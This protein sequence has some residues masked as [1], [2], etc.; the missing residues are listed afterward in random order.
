[1]IVT[2]LPALLLVAASLVLGACASDDDKL[3]PSN[4]FRDEVP[5]RLQ[6]LQ[7][8]EV[9][10]LARRSLDAADYDGAIG[11]YRAILLRF[12]FSEYATQAQLELI[13]ANYKSYS[14][15]SALADAD[16]FLRE[17]PRHPQIEYVYYLRGLIHYSRANARGDLLPWSDSHTYDPTYARRAFDAFAQLIQRYPDSK[18]APDARQ[19]MILLRDRLTQ[20]DLEIVR[21][22]LKRKAYVGASRRAE[23]MLERYQGTS[24]IPETLTLL[25]TAYRKL[26]LTELADATAALATANYGESIPASDTPATDEQSEESPKRLRL[27]PIIDR[28]FKKDDD[29]E[30]A[31]GEEPAKTRGGARQST[32]T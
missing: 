4:P 8:D 5:K 6:R 11:Q 16:R 32:D 3:A 23:E 21:Y 27:P 20:H 28:W 13:Y 26:E 10:R 1:M 22:Y 18:Y 19:R 24:V 31:S 12:P 15:D 14:P 7:A 2:R 17:H 29:E 25:E 30:P 9:Y